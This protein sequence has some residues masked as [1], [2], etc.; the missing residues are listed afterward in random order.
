MVPIRGGPN[1]YKKDAKIGNNRGEPNLDKKDAKIGKNRGGQNLD[2]KMP[3][4]ANIFFKFKYFK[5]N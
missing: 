4:S 1:L 2:K 5:N 3:R